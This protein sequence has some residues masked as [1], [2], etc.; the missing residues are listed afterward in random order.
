[1]NTKHG[2]NILSLFDGISN[3]QISTSHLGISINKYYASEICPR[4]I[5]NTQFRY[6]ET[7]QLG[8]V[9]NV[10]GTSL[11][12]IDILVAGFPC[13]DLSSIRQNRQSLAGEKSGLFFEV[14]RIIKEV[15]P[16]YFLIENVKS[17]S[18]HSKNVISDLLGV[19][20]ICINSNLVSAQNRNR[21][22]WTNIPNIE[23][24]K[25]RKIKLQ[26]IIEN[27]YVD[28]L[29]ANCCLSK[30]VPHSK[31]G[32]IRYIS[33][34]LGQVAFYEKDFAYASKDEKLG[35]I[36]HMNNDEVK[37]LFRLFTI[38]EIESLQTIPPGYV[39]DVLKKTPS[40]VAIGK[41]FTTEIIKHILSYADFK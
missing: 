22:Y 8:D 35:I 34:S 39:T 33:K 4:A 16:K 24:P 30:N 21:L 3:F 7:I 18:E 41:S 12:Q 31:N 38:K 10:D 9:K 25:D 23:P 15:K 28:R 1:M 29:K 5:M 27:G 19:Q 26:S 32:L 2:I 11:P 17:M 37:K 40:H 14:L 20:P 6:P 13:V 36:E